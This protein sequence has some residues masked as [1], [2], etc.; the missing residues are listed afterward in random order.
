M[1]DG[2]RA[3]L[4]VY[5]TSRP[6]IGKMK[7]QREATIRREIGLNEVEKLQSPPLKQPKVVGID[8]GQTYTVA[9]VCIQDGLAT[10]DLA[11][12]KSAL[13]G[14]MRNRGRQLERRK[15]V[16]VRAAECRLCRPD[17]TLESVTKSV[18]SWIQNCDALFSFYFRKSIRRL[19]QHAVIARRALFDMTTDKILR[20]PGGSISEKDG[21]SSE[22]IGPPTAPIVFAVGMAD[23]ASTT[24]GLPSLHTAFGGHFIAKARSQGYQVVGVDEYNTSSRFAWCQGPLQAK[25]M[26]IKKCIRCKKLYH[27][28]KIA[29]EAQARIASNILTGQPRPACWTSPERA[30]RQAEIA[31]EDV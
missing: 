31:N 17:I 5:D 29:G 22:F 23:F 28:D 11:V 15:T 16:E 19:T 1:T 7:L 18:C 8:L 10:T 2:L 25:G 6:P 27:R 9:A 12:R 20:M 14:P 3:K 26:R 13:E 21:M 4:I 24:G 30:Q